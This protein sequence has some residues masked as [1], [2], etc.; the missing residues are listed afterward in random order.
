RKLRGKGGALDDPA[1]LQRLLRGAGV[2]EFRLLA[3]YDASNPHEYDRYV[4]NLQKRGPRKMPED[5]LGWFAIDDPAYFF[6]SDLRGKQRDFDAEFPQLKRRFCVAEKYGDKYYVL[7]HL[8]DNK[9]L[10]QNPQGGSDW[11]LKSAVPTRD[12]EGKPAVSFTLD[13][14]GGSKFRKL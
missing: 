5:T 10:A 12:Q 13:E 7:A 1:D 4:D 2:L 9:S 8:E 3:A 6:H 11:Q 14:K